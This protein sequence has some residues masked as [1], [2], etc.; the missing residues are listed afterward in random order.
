MRSSPPQ[1]SKGN[2]DVNDLLHTLRGEHFRRALNSQRIPAAALLPTSPALGPSLPYAEIYGLQPHRFSSQ[3]LHIDAKVT[4]TLVAGP[5]PR[6]W[7]V[8]T[9]PSQAFESPEW[10]ETALS[11]FFAQNGGSSGPVADARPAVPRLGEFCLRVILRCCGTD[12]DVLRDFVPYLGPHLKKQLMRICA[13]RCP[14]PSASLRVLLGEENNQV[15]GELIVVEPTSPLR[16]ELFQSEQSQVQRDPEGLWDADGPSPQPLTALA[17]MSAALSTPTLL[18]FPPSITRLALVHL[19]APV[20]LHRLPDKCPLLEVLD[21]SY[22][23]WLGEPA[24]GG[25]QAL[26]KVAWQ[27]WAYLKILGCRE[28]GI[29]LEELRKVNEGRWDDVRIVT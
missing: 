4:P 9:A 21:I 1:S 24:W 7:V 12:A 20:P 2:K 8:T 15:D 6:S 13:V 22:N 17:I 25:E 23:P 26:E 16:P 18:A 14:L 10:R 29:A 5:I 11:L 27:R 28:C 3:A 19:S